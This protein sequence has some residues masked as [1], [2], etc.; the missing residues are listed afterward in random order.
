MKMKS[1]SSSHSSPNG[2]P[3]RNMHSQT[4]SKQIKY[5]YPAKLLSLDEIARNYPST[6]RLLAIL[7]S[8]RVRVFVRKIQGGGRILYL[9]H[10]TLGRQG[11]DHHKRFYR[12]FLEHNTVFPLNVDVFGALAFATAQFFYDLHDFI[13]VNV[14]FFSLS[15][16]IQ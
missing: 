8:L 11:N 3:K 15:L 16:H 5:N 14:L 6:C 4:G 12:I 9:S 1:E 10:V 13:A 2:N 7:F